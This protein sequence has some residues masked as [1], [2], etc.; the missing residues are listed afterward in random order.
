[1]RKVRILLVSMPALLRDILV[2][3]LEVQLDMEVVG[4]LGG[5][6][7]LL[8]DAG[9]TRADVV[10]LGL[11]Q[12]DLPGI[13]T[14]LLAEYPHLSVLAVTTDGR[15]ASLFELRPRKTSIGDVSPQG[16]VDAIRAAWNENLSMR[17]P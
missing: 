10:V 5:G 6:I 8:V 16:L 12:M 3:T 17:S 4:D 2:Q 15:A 1:M 14:N 11:E 9:H 7:E 13:A